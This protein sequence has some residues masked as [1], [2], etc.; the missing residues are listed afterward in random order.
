MARSHPAG[1]CRQRVRRRAE[2]ITIKGCHI[3]RRNARG[4][5]VVSPY[6]PEPKGTLRPVL[7]TAGPCHGED[8]R[9]CKLFSDHDR[10]RTTGPGFP[11][12]VMRCRAHNRGFTVYPPGHFPYGRVPLAPVAADGH[13]LLSEPG[14]GAQRFRGT[15]FE[16]AL[17]ASQ[18]RAWPKECEDGDRRARFP[19]QV[20]HLEQAARVLGVHPQLGAGAQEAA[21]AILAVPGQVVHEGACLIE[22]QPGYRSWGQAICGVLD[23][24]LMRRTLFARL[25]ECGA[26]VGLWPRPE[27]WEHGRRHRP[28]FQRVRTRAPPAG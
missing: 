1:P 10:D 27:F 7:P 2:K 12:R 18:G 14:G 5:F 28:S 21:M 3:T 26:R 16:A 8:G 13:E 9:A 15:L 25:A 24:L 19:T 23:E 20:R 22:S 4:S 17:D 6:F 11:I